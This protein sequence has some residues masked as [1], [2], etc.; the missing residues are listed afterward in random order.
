M[1]A[2]PSLSGAAG[3]IEHWRDGKIINTWFDETEYSY[4]LPVFNQ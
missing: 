1:L 4:D 2:Y 3:K